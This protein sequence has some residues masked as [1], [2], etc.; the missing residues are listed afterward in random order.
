MLAVDTLTPQQ[1]ERIAAIARARWGLSLTASKVQLVTS[2]LSA[3]LRKSPFTDVADYLRHLEHGADE[4]DMLVFFDLLSTN[5][6]SFFRDRAHFDYLERELFTSIARGNITLPARKLR[7]WSAGCST[8]CEPY[9]LAM[10]AHESMKDLS[11]WDVQILATD[12][13]NYAVR[14]ARAAT[15]TQDTIKA[16]PADVLARHFDRAGAGDSWTVKPHLRAMVKVGQLNLMEKW[17]M[18]GPFDVIFCRNVM[19]YF[20]AATRERLV[21]RFAQLLRPGGIFAV[22]SAETLA[23]MNVGLRSAMPSLYVK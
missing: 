6:T 7:I 16:L 1:F 14:E 4:K 13:S 2:R 22:G 23:G 3:F 19:I 9:T 12:L 18:N 21:K 15:Y 10:V 20:D 8:G 11:G 5:V 17:P